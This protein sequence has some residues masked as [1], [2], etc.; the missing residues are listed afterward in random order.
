MKIQVHDGLLWF[1]GKPLKVHHADQIAQ[2]NGY[3]FAERFVRA[4]DGK[5]VEIG[6]D[7]KLILESKGPAERN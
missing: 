1:N 2:V 5:E 6:P 3:Q 4:F 7:Q